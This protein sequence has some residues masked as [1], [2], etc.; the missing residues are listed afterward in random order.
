MFQLPN[1]STL[2][3]ADLTPLTSRFE[4][5]KHLANGFASSVTGSLKTIAIGAAAAGAALAVGVGAFLANAAHDAFEL[6][7]SLHDM[8]INVGVSVESLHGLGLA[9]QQSGASVGVAADAYK[10][11]GRNV[12]EAVTGN[13]TAIASFRELGVQFK[14]ASGHA[15][16]LEDVMFDVADALAEMGEGGDRTKLAMELMGRGGTEMIATLSQGSTAIKEQIATFKSYGAVITKEAADSADAFGDLWGEVKIAWTGIK[17]TIGQPILDALTPVL[18]GAV[19]WVRANIPQIRE[20]ITSAVHD[21]IDVATSLFD[22]LRNL[23]PIATAVGGALLT[24]AQG[25][26]FVLSG[27]SSGS[28]AATSWADEWSSA[29]DRVAASGEK[30]AG[31]AKAMGGFDADKWLKDANASIDKDINKDIDKA[32]DAFFGSDEDI[33]AAAKKRTESITAALDRMRHDIQT[34][35][36]SDSDK[37][38][39]DW[40]SLMPGEAMNGEFERLAKQM[41]QLQDRKKRF[42]GVDQFKLSVR[43]PVE[44]FDAKMKE[45]KAW[46]DI[47]AITAAQFDRG[48]AIEQDKLAALLP[49][50]QEQGRLPSFI[51]SGSAEQMRMQFSMQQQRDPIPAQQLKKAEEQRKLLADIKDRLNFTPK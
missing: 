8:A 30:L 27:F 21:M 39:F 2:I 14:D 38:R 17:N 15:R 11:L 46:R 13:K 44:E 9:A 42:E 37:M 45:M 16:P 3:T 26:S 35:G 51:R 22:I 43:N 40:K 10:F 33:E 4:E 5:G 28:G 49:G 18:R 34:F 31:G 20:V 7:D 50:R 6:G 32:L 25:I 41:D 23:T 19:D 29:F 36:M 47:E 24:V 12:A 1:I 48:V